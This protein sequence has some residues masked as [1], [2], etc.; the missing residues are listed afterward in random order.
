M[1]KC[2]INERLF[3]SEVK[4]RATQGEIMQSNSELNCYLGMRLS[5]SK[6][7][8]VSW[9]PNRFAGNHGARFNLSNVNRIVE[10][11]L[12]KYPKGATV[13]LN[14][15]G[16]IVKFHKDGTIAELGTIDNLPTI[17]KLEVN[18]SNLKP[19]MIWGGPFDGDTHHFCDSRFWANNIK[20]RRCHWKSV[21]EQLKSSL[22]LYKPLGG[23]F[24]ITPWNHVI[25]LIQPIPLPDEA[26]AQWNSFSKEEKRLVQI[27]QKSIEMLPIYI[28]KMDED[29][30]IELDEPVDY[31]KPLSKEEIGDMLDFLKQFSDGTK[32]KQKEEQKTEEKIDDVEEDWSDDEEF[33]DEEG[34]DVLY[35]PSEVGV[36]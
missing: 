22:E 13:K 17:D 11:V 6:D 34:L 36:E 31:S 3:F 35:T 26:Q 25:A 21:P 18:P 10:I 30:G 8:T 2:S 9:Q 5:V 4:I 23:S 24:I 32:S 15:E 27:K 28:C 1:L 29:W 16:D 14:R 12:A 7:R 20:R 33:F 19:G